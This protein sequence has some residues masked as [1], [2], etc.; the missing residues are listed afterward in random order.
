MHWREGGKNERRKGWMKG[1]REKLMSGTYGETD[2]LE[3]WRNKWDEERDGRIEGG[4]T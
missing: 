2:T 3:G 1:E 4:R